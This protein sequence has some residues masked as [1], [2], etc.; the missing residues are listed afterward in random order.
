MEITEMEW[1][2]VNSRIADLERKVQGQQK[3]IGRRLNVTLNEA[4]EMHGLQPIE[5]GD[6]I[7]TPLV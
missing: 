1:E 7:L 2:E 4:R 3:I 5:D 6:E